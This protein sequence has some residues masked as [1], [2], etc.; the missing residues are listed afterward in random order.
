MP[1][2][3]RKNA[4]NRLFPQNQDSDNPG[5]KCLGQYCNINI[6][7]SFLISLLRQCILFEIFLQFSLT[8]PYKKLKLGKNSGYTRPTLFVGW[9][10]GMGLCEL[11]N[12]PET[13]VSRDFCPWLSEKE[14]GRKKSIL[15]GFQACK[16]VFSGF[17]W[18]M[19]F[20]QTFSQLFRVFWTCFK[21]TLE[22][23]DITQKLWNLIACAI[24][25]RI[26]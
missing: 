21:N 7:L 16:S 10:E 13:Q 3:R 24:F 1:N 5:Q 9:G 23:N 4:D 17:W 26:T 19:V 25:Q 14:V 2:K 22:M 12:A 18:K 20:E 8:P 11:E 6:F 15:S